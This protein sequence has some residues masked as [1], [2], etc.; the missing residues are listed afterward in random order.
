[1]SD[2]RKFL[3]TFQNEKGQTLD[4]HIENTLT[5]LLLKN[6]K[7]WFEAFEDESL[8][9]KK[10]DFSLQNLDVDDNNYRL[11]EKFTEVKDWGA[12]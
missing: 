2:L 10:K 4:Q 12:K 11:R 8:R 7:N 5:R 3:Q 9:V 1:M 6:P